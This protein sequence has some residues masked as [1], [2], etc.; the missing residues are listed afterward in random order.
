MSKKYATVEDFVV[1][2][3]LLNMAAKEG[4][5]LTPLQINK[6]IYICHGWAWGK[7][8]RPLIENRLGQIEAWKYGPVIRNVYERLKKWRAEGITF[9]SFCED[10]GSYG[11][12]KKDATDYLVGE[13]TNLN[14]QDPEMSKLIDL[15]WRVYKDLTGGQLITITHKEETPWRKHVKYGMFKRVVHGV[16]IPDSTI[17]DHYRVKLQNTPQLSDV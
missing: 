9:D 4:K 13:I 12:G 10:F 5:G 15:V 8:N 14:E 3:Y 11:M 17:A 1:I 2:A 16:H 6:L 7:L